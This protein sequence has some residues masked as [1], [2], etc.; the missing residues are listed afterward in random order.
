MG[1]TI[2]PDTSLEDD[3]T[4]IKYDAAQH[5]LKGRASTG[6]HAQFG[7]LGFRHKADHRR[8][9]ILTKLDFGCSRLKQFLEN[10]WF[11]LSE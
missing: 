4:L 1:E 6:E 11:V 10:I 8:G 3:A 9:K 7:I 5:P 2:D